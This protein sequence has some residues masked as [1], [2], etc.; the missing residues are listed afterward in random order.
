VLKIPRNFRFQKCKNSFLPK[1]AK[2]SALLLT[3]H[4]VKVVKV[5]GMHTLHE[6]IPVYTLVENVYTS[7][8][9]CP[10]KIPPC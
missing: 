8:S 1:F 7:I 2:L 6:H 5:V 3:M 10:T 4:T 9:V